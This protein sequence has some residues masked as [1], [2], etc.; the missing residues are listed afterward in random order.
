MRSKKKTIE[1]LA[2][3][4][5]GVAAILLLWSAAALAADSEYILPT[6]GQTLSAAFS[7]LK[8]KAF[9]LSLGGTLLR[10]FLSFAISFFIAFAFA[11][12]SYKS[13]RFQKIAAPFVKTIRAL[14][15]VAVVLLLLFWTN[16]RVA[17]VIVTML[18]V[19]PS[20]Y[21]DLLNAFFGIDKEAV[22]MCKCFSVSRKEVLFKV[23]IPQALPPTLYSAGAGLS[24]NLKLMVAAEVLAQT[25][26]SMGY[27]LN[28][29]KVYF[30]IA[31]MLALVV[32]TV[33]IGTAI[34]SVFG[35][36][37]KKTGKNL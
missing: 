23:E 37:S 7:L 6:V 1:N 29:A 2:Y 25:A 5:I 28:T 35:A 22:E 27:L 14:P 10:A 30:E 21:T 4:A 32:V 36:L 3:T 34:E 11:F 26:N 12:F 18:V 33:V 16:S 19:L 13:E 31:D 24:L 15:T 20:L 9:Y 8:S 17:P